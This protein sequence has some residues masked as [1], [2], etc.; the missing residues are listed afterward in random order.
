MDYY[1]GRLWYAQAR[2]ISGSDM[3][4][5]PAGTAGEHYRDAILNVTENPLCVGGD[6]F[7]VPTNAGNIRAIFHSAN[8]N[9]ALG[10]GQL[11]IG[12][13]KVIYSLEVPVT[14]TDWINASSQNQPLMTVVQLVNGPVND[15]S[16]V[17]ENGD[18]F[19]QSLEPGIRS[20]Q[21]SLRNFGQWG[22]TAIS[23]N[24]YRALAA[25]DRGLMRFSGGIEFDNRSLQLVL[26]VLAADGV[27]V[28]HQAVLPLDFFVVNN[29]RT[30][31]PTNVS[32]TSALMPPVW[33]GRT[34]A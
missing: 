29:L 9:S 22:N 3:V 19:Y 14:R 23:Q 7:T 20:L 4:G 10:Q 1:A 26:P 24:E 13:R 33:R 8:L 17:Q 31:G 2:Q 12:T 6:G 28:I 5:G 27:N 30:Q 34:T 16:V 15:R 25:N 32:G 18:I 21:V 11:F